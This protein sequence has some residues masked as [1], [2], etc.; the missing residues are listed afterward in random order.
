[1]GAGPFHSLSPHFLVWEMEELEF[2][3]KSVCKPAGGF[4]LAA[5]GSALR[6]A[7]LLSLFV[8]LALGSQ[9][10]PLILFMSYLALQD[11][12]VHKP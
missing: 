8:V 7:L 4:Y 9:A 12:S 2:K 10:P 5:M 3:D 6:F 1:M 11:I